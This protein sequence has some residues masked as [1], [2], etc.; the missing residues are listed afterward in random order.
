MFSLLSRFAQ[1][2]RK[3]K[4]LRENSFP[5]FCISVRKNPAIITY[6]QKRNFGSLHGSSPSRTI[7]NAGLVP[8]D[9]T[10]KVNL[11]HI[12]PLSSEKHWN[13][14]EPEM[15]A[16]LYNRIGNLVLLNARKNSKI[17]DFGFKEKRKVF[18]ESPFLLTKSVAK[19]QTWSDDEVSERQLE[20][21]ELAVQTWPLAVK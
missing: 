3:I 7:D 12:I 13:H 9:D 14:I 10:L 2:T 19:Y 20:L 15:A 5:K 6:G 18:A 16:S 1:R 11:E 17:G 21:A 8:D 4:D